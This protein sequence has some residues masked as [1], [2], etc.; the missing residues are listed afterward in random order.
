[1]KDKKYI[2]DKAC[3]SCGQCV[4]ACKFHAVTIL[5]THGYARFI[6][7]DNCKGCGEC[8]AICPGEAIK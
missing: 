2:D 8:A 4:E 1:M 5:K 3:M 6:I 7:N